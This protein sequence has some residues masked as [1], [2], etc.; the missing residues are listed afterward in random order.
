MAHI[1]IPGE[2]NPTKRGKDCPDFIPMKDG[3]KTGDPNYCGRS[4]ECR[5][6]G[7]RAHFVE[8]IDSK[9]GEIVRVDYLCTGVFGTPDERGLDFE[10]R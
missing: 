8:V 3:T 4:L 2:I 5:Q 9:T 1:I 6:D 7:M 10:A